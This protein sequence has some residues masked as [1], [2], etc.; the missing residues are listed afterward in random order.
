MMRKAWFYFQDL[1]LSA[2]LA[3]SGRA[4][5]SAESGGQSSHTPI[6]WKVW[7]HCTYILAPSEGTQVLRVSGS[8]QNLHRVSVEV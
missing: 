6:P 8:A 2:E 1:M 4:W 7:H 3:A 5:H